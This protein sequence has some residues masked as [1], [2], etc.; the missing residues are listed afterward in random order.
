MRRVAKAR[1]RET[2]AAFGCSGGED[3]DSVDELKERNINLEEEGIDLLKLISG[4]G[5]R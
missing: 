5:Y 1:N 2:A 3:A 4:E